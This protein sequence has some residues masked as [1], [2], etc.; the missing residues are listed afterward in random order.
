MNLR[1]KYIYKCNAKNV[2]L[3][4]SYLFAQYI[5]VKIYKVGKLKILLKLKIKNPDEIK[6]KIKKMN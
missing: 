4:F 1:N 5:R 2:T 6:L 3:S